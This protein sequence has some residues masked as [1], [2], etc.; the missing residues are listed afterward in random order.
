MEVA[1]LLNYV[2]SLLNYRVER[3]VILNDITQDKNKVL[4][5]KNKKTVKFHKLVRI[6]K[7]AVS[8]FQS[9]FEAEQGNGVSQ[10]K[11]PLA[12]IKNPPEGQ[13]MNRV[14]IEPSRYLKEFI[15]IP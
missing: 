5:D 13:I 7:K 8:I 2:A 11:R 10:Q 1:S 14:R 3:T 15:S 4:G 9:V 6:M 12:E